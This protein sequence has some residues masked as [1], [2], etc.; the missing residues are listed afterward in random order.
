MTLGRKPKPLTWGMNVGSLPPLY[1]PYYVMSRYINKR[2]FSL[3]LIASF[4]F[5]LI[6]PAF[7][8]IAFVASCCL[9][10]Y[11]SCLC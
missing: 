10:D 5:S 6:L 7:S 8:Y 9:S 4:L 3:L 1:T 2:K 11:V